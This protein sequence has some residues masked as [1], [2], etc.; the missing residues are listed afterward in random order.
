MDAYTSWSI[1]YVFSLVLKYH[2]HVLT[3][4]FQGVIEGHW[5]I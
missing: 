2:I 1:T 4:W 3:A 5:K